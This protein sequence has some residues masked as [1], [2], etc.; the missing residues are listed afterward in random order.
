MQVMIRNGL[1][2]PQ[3]DLTSAKTSG[4]EMA[5]FPACLAASSLIRRKIQLQPDLVV[6]LVE[7]E[8]AA[9]PSCA[10]E[11]VKS[12][13][14][15]SHA[16]PQLVAGIVEVAAMAA[17]E[18]LRMISQCAIASAPDSAMAVHRVLAKIDP[19]GKLRG[20]G[21]KDAKIGLDV[22]ICPVAG[23]SLPNPLDVN[24]LQA[25]LPLPVNPPVVTFV[26][27]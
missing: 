7:A 9:N 3:A 22:T 5:V 27:P 4:V 18:H 19:S 12:A 15:A 10:C 2:V 23:A 14:H 13:I 1:A 24:P 11:I 21:P 17:P 26:D 8:V 16:N 20:S 25:V 6:E